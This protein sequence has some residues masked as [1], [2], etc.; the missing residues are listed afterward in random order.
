MS[1][2]QILV[3]L[4]GLAA[5]LWVNWYFLFARRAATVAETGARG[6]QES[7]IVVQGGYS[8]AV[9][10]VKKGLP[11]RLTFD[12]Q[13]TSSCSEEIVFP[14]FGIRKF[15]PAHQQTVIEFTPETPGSFDFTCGM[16]MLRGKLIVE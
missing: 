12:R 5:I 8:P 11:V 13:E 15:L 1:T 14:D 6:V 7:V 4:A 3:L 16:S 9:I 10:K 2:S